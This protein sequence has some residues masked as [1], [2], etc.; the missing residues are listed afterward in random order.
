MQTY[1]TKP[2]VGTREPAAT[3]LRTASSSS[4]SSPP[5]FTA[6]PPVHRGAPCARTC[7]SIRGTAAE[8]ERDG[9]RPCLRCRPLA[10]L[11]RDPNAERIRKIC[12]YIET[13][14]ASDL[15]PA[16]ALSLDQLA[17][18]AGLSRF[19]FLRSFQAIVGVTPKHYVEACRMKQLKANLRQCTHDVTA[20]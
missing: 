16:G 20:A 11:N 18:R 12:R 6:G 7:A 17:T 5:E 13:A 2:P 4:A 9:L 19:H 14:H 8:A 15:D 3:R 10:I 1:S